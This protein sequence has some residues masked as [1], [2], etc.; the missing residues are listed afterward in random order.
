MASMQTLGVTFTETFAR[1][2]KTHCAP[3]G[4]HVIYQTGL[5]RL[6]T[7]HLCVP[8]MSSVKHALLFL[9]HKFEHQ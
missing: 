8:R 5:D 9:T 6:F 2:V 4:I 1:C 7:C 3:E